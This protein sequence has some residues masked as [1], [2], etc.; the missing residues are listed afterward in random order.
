MF[1]RGDVAVVFDSKTGCRQF[2]PFRLVEHDPFAVAVLQFVFQW[3]ERQITGDGQC[4]HQF[5]RCNERMSIRVAVGPFGKVA[6]ERR[7]DRVR[8]G[9]VL[10]VAGPLS[11]TGSAGVGHHNS[12]DLQQ[13]LQDSV[14]FGRIAD[15]FRSRVDQQFRLGF[16]LFA[17]RLPCNGGCS[18]QILIGRVGA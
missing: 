16:Q 7:N 12:A 13:R 5:G 1:V 6:V 18:A 14:A 11:D 15:L 17:D 9:V 8:T 10:F 2:V 3:V 4:G